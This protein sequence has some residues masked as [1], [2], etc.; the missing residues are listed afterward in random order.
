[1]TSL[2]IELYEESPAAYEPHDPATLDVARAV[3][4]LIESALGERGVTGARVEHFGST[5][6]PGLAG[7]GVVDLLLLY[8]EGALATAR[9]VLAALGFQPQGTRDPF[10]EERPM[11]L[12]SVLWRGRRYRL[13]VHVVAEDA[14]EAAR[15]IRFRDRLR[16]DPA[17]CAAYEARKREILAAG[18]DDTVDYAEAKTSF[19]VAASE[20]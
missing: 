7:K 13:H 8:P 14:D 2:R 17:L 19:I 4:T 9:D 3:G 10:P 20:P 5:A 16:T 15:L 6:V 11:R 1:M 12:G 18:I